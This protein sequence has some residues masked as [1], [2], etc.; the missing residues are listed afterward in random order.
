MDQWLDVLGEKKQLEEEESKIML[1]YVSINLLEQDV[2]FSVHG[3]LHVN[4]FE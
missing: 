3:N 4:Y 1:Q 2:H